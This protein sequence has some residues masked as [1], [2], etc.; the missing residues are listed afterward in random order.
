LGGGL[1][2]FINSKGFSCDNIIG[3]RIVTG[4]GDITA[5]SSEST[6][7]EKQLLNLLRG[8]G[9]GLGV[10]ISVTLRLY[11]VAELGL[12]EGN[13]C[14]SAIAMFS[15]DNF[16]FVAELWESVTP[17]TQGGIFAGFMFSVG[18]PGSPL[19]GQPVIMLSLRYTGPPA[20][21]KKAFEPFL[22]SEV[23]KHASM[24]HEFTF[25]LE[26]MNDQ[27][28]ANMTKGRNM[29][30]FNSMIA[31]ISGASL[32]AAANRWLEFIDKVG[33]TVKCMSVLALWNK[34]AL[35]DADPAGQ[36]G[37]CHRD[38]E[39]MLQ[40][41]FWDV[42][43][44]K[45]AE[46]EK[47]AVDVQRIARSE[48]VEKGLPNRTLPGVGRVMVDMNDLYTPEILELLKKTKGRWDPKG[49]FWSP[50]VD[51]WSY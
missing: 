46:A 24:V 23:R 5:L 39:F 50:A 10:V 22:T 38:R 29:D 32:L 33:P 25:P 9:S 42:D 3:V 4:T 13:A 35:L 45:I 17:V 14:P 12:A 40:T 47:Y 37:N 18:P 41:I 6:G 8:A 43:E 36:S 28:D 15:R 48:D 44:D 7:D 26:N 19:A 2:L 16:E 30:C 27:G 11:P 21:A 34:Q 51:G 20:A 31:S 1:N 49:V